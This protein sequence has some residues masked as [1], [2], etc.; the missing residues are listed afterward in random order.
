LDWDCSTL[1]KRVV[2]FKHVPS[3]YTVYAHPADNNLLNENFYTNNVRPLSIAGDFRFYE[4]NTPISE[5]DQAVLM[6]LEI[7]PVDL[8]NAKGKTIVL[9]QMN[10]EDSK[11]WKVLAVPSPV[12]VYDEKTK[13]S[14]VDIKFTKWQTDPASG[15]GVGND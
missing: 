6:T 4:G 2:I 3:S 8:E 13:T 5:F 1:A 9:V 11:G 14:V 15:P 7:T 12:R 10:P